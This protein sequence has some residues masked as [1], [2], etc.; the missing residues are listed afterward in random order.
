M[1]AHMKTLQM[2]MRMSTR[3][4]GLLPDVNRRGMLYLLF[5][6]AKEAQCQLLHAFVL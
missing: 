3:S 4:A 6:P 1:Y 2:G 5:P